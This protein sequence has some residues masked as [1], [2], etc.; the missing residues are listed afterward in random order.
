MTIKNLHIPKRSGLGEK[1]VTVLA[2]DIGGTK[3]NLAF[4]QATDSGLTMLETG[5]YP[6]AEYA[7]CVA[8]MQQ[9]LSEKKCS[10]PDRICLGVAGPVLNGKVNL[11]NLNWDIDI[12]E[13]KKFTAADK[14]YLP[15]DKEHNAYK[16]V[17]E[18]Y[19]NGH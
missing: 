19:V 6:S 13:V 16:E 12:Q 9:F 11:T 5:R 4:Y 10:K 15:Q 1:G 17:F 14:T 18:R 3:T 2:G 7:S 8:I